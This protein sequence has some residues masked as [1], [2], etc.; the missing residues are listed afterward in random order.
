L[1]YQE[2][3]RDTVEREYGGRWLLVCERDGSAGVGRRETRSIWATSEIQYRSVRELGQ[4]WWAGLLGSTELGGWVVSGPVL[5]VRE[6]DL[7]RPIGGSSRNL[8]CFRCRSVR[9]LGEKWWAGLLG[10]TSASDLGGRSVLGPTKRELAVGWESELCRRS[11][12]MASDLRP[13]GRSAGFEG[14]RERASGIGVGFPVGGGGH[15]GEGRFGK[16]GKF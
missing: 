15:G 10:S 12:A 7:G 14:L 4:K 3:E 2:R 16:W 8:V 11:L 13:V 6:K 1:A 9:E 5:W